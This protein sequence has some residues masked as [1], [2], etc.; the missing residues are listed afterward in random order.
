MKK[1]SPRKAGTFDQVC[2]LKTDNKS[3]ESTCTETR[4]Q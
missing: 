4:I 3:T 2:S 1:L